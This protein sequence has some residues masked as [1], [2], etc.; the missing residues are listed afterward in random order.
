MACV[1]RNVLLTNLMSG[2]VDPVFGVA[3]TITKNFLVY[4]LR[5]RKRG[6]L[7]LMTL[8]LHAINFFS[9]AT[10]DADFAV[11]AARS[12]AKQVVL[13]GDMTSVPR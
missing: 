12:L 4:I 8:K 11:D 6:C 2:P 3:A 13:G 7:L 9:A 10:S 1:S 5:S